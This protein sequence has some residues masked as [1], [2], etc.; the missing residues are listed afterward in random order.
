MLL[1]KLSGVTESAASPSN[2]HVND[3]ENVQQIPR[4][5][6]AE[7]GN[8]KFAQFKKGKNRREVKK[9][10]NFG[11]FFQMILCWKE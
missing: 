4:R 5:N 11:S 6:G 8:E 1:V 7:N 10:T 3:E 9:E 2:H